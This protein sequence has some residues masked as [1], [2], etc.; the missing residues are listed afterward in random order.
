MPEPAVG[1]T[2]G[3]V[4]IEVA[5][6]VAYPSLLGYARLLTGDRA[7]AEDVVHEAL[8]RC[9]RRG[10]RVAIRQV[11]AYARRAV[12]NEFLRETRHRGRAPRLEL[13]GAASPQER[14]NE[15]DELRAWLAHLPVRQ[16]TAVVSR[17]YLDLSEKETAELLGCSA[18]AVKS[19]C[20]RGIMLLRDEAGGRYPR[21]DHDRLF[22]D[23]ADDTNRIAMEER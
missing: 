23:R 9:L 14:V 10:R 7:R 2:D 20:H 1:G 18:S 5:L 22:G 17:Y 11:T 4:E 13:E 21:A 15:R 12:L 8:V 6:T 19:L 16:R 3:D